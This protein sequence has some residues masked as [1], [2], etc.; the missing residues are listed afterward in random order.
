[1]PIDRGMDKEDVVIY[2][3][4]HYS[5]IKESEVMPSVAARRRRGAVTLRETGQTQK[6]KHHGWHC[7]V[8]SRGTAQRTH[9][10]NRGRP[11]DRKETVVTRGG[12]RGGG[13]KSGV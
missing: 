11:T 6:D 10:Q 8:G 12:G 1:M 13:E 7:R 4:E 3:E 2:A 5:D 9:P